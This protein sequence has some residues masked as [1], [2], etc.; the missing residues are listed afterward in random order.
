MQVQIGV[1]L[2][3]LQILFKPHD[4]TQGSL[5]FCRMQALLL[6]HSAFIKHSGRQFGGTPI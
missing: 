2:T 4:P 5:H 6:A 3:I 1:W